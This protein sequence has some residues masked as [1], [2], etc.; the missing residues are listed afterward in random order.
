MFQRLNQWIQKQISN[1][2]LILQHSN[3][4]KKFKREKRPYAE[5]LVNEHVLIAKEELEKQVI[6]KQEGIELKVIVLEKIPTKT[7]GVW[8]YRCGLLI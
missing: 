8:S 1:E 7:E 5:D 4:H 6:E 2:D 3:I